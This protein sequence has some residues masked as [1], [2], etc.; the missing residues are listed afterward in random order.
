[1]WETDVGD[2]EL[3]GR[4]REKGV[5]GWERGLCGDCTSQHDVPTSKC[6]HGPS[7]SGGGSSK[8]ALAPMSRQFSLFYLKQISTNKEPSSMRWLPQA[9]PTFPQYW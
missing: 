3:G 4:L 8:E 2:K 6:V 1:M 5:M 9:E 7:T